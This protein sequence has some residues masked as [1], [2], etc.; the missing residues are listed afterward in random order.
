MVKTGV[1]GVKYLDL[2]KYVES[3]ILDQV[4]E[5]LVCAWT[6][7][8]PI[9]QS[10]CT[11][12]KN[13][14]LPYPC[15]IAKKVKLDSVLRMNEVRSYWKM[16]RF[17]DGGVMKDSKSNM[18]ILNEWETHQLQNLKKSVFKG[19]RIR[20]SPPSPPPQ[21]IPF[22]DG[23][24]I[25]MHKYIKGI[26]NVKGDDN[27]GYRAV[28]N[29]LGK[30]ED[31]HTPVLH[32]LIHELKTHKESYTRLYR[33]KEN[34]DA[35]Y[36][37]FVPCI[38]GPTLKEKW[39]CFLEMGHLIT[40]VYDI[41]CID[42][43]R[44]GFSETLFPLRTTPPQNPNDH[45]ICIWWL[46]KSWHFG[47]LYLNPGYPIPLTSLEWTSHSTTKSETWPNQFVERMQEFEKLSNIEIES[48]AQ[49]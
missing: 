43:T 21:K 20:K 9:A 8:A 25:F 37:T 11:I 48:N 15:L 17:D 13:Y 41:T 45:I 36:E 38:S 49:K 19:V 18:S 47:Q 22:I 23:M 4:K 27:Y 30:G 12:V 42:L 24:L 1:E 28:S 34:F 31:N 6:D 46:S 29:L 32:Q 26:I 2:L 5:K 33:K 44:Y 16:F 10:G 3:T 7:Q 40:C 39:T 14:G 35:I